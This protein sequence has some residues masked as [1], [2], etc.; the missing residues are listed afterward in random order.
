MRSSSCRQCNDSSLHSQSVSTSSSV[1]I[2]YGHEHAGTYVQGTQLFIR[3]FELGV[4]FLPSLEARY[5]QH[6]N[7]GFSCNP[8][9]PPA[10]PSAEDAST[11]NA[12]NEPP[13]DPLAAAAAAAGEQLCLVWHM[14]QAIS[15]QHTRLQ[16]RPHEDPS[17]LRGT[18][19]TAH[20]CC[21]TKLLILALPSALCQQ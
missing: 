10:H 6:P 16:H 12:V 21:M 18:D 19:T 9:A 5:R 3:S 8:Q 13:A 2:I 15:H 14:S 11:C 7:R 1:N 17:W 20:S 4:M